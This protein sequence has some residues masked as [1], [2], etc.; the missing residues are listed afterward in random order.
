MSVVAD[1]I[2]KRQMLALSPS[3]DIFIKLLNLF[4][5]LFPPPL[6][7][8]S[9]KTLHLR[10][11]R[12]ATGST[13]Q[14]AFCNVWEI[15]STVEALHQHTATAKSSPPHSVRVLARERLLT[16]CPT[17]QWLKHSNLFLM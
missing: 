4:L 15:L 5:P 7:N 10:G 12:G 13:A 6:Q 2:Q 3:L 16:K 8:R 11:L 1:G 17:S 14:G 9:N